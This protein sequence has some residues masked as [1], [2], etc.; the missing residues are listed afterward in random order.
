[1]ADVGLEGRVARPGDGETDIRRAAIASESIEDQL[2]HG[3]SRAVLGFNGVTATLDHLSHGGRNSQF[4]L[5]AAV[6]L[7]ALRDRAPHP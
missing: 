3:F 5:G 1:M 6:P 2:E 7:V 4:V